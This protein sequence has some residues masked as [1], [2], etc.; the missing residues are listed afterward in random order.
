MLVA[1]ADG[2]MTP[3]QVAMT[4][5]DSNSPMRAQDVSSKSGGCSVCSRRNQ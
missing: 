1:Q 4:P 2:G 5:Y 3:G